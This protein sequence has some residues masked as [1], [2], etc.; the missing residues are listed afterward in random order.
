[1]H[2]Q[3]SKGE[4]VMMVGGGP[5]DVIEEERGS[6]KWPWVLLFPAPALLCCCMDGEGKKRDRSKDCSSSSC[7]CCIHPGLLLAFYGQE[8]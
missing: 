5:C 4:E 6:C 3:A 2:R 1:V 8:E 7:C